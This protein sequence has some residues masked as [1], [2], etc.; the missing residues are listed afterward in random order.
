MNSSIQKIIVIEG[1]DKTG[2]STFSNIFSN[3]YSQKFSDDLVRFSFPNKTTPIGRSIRNELESEKPDLDVV[4]APN[5]IA[6]MIHYWMKEIYKYEYTQH[7]KTNV[8][9]LFDR[10]FISTLAYQAFYYDN[11]D[12]LN[13]IKDSIK[14]NKFLKI[15]TDLIVLNL[16][17]SIIIER[18][19]KD[20]KTNQVDAHDTK[21]ESI[22][23]KRR[24]AYKYAVDVMYDYGTNIHWVDD[25]SLY[26]SN[27][28]A[29]DLLG[30][31]FQ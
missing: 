30:K 27:T 2:K 22:L 28:L 3:A 12:N 11:M 7:Q 18:T 29:I 13:F 25:V 9:Y 1:L 8:N 5:F 19:I 16:P 23:N 14:N 24:E 17:N 26:D 10:Y 4:S 20:E 6:E 31:I 21:D 15:P